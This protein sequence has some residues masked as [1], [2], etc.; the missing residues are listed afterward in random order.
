MVLSYI[1][2]TLTQLSCIV[3]CSTSSVVH[4]GMFIVLLMENRIDVCHL[5][6]I[7]TCVTLEIEI[8]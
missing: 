1:H 7:W 4:T 8:V 2:G 6:I 3:Y 5:E